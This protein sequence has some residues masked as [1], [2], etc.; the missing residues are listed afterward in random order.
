MDC[1]GRYFF[2]HLSAPSVICKFQCC[3]ILYE[4]S[5]EGLVGLLI[6]FYNEL[7][8]LVIIFLI[9]TRARGA[10]PIY[11]HIIRPFIKPYTETLDCLLDFMF[12]I[13][14]IA[15]AM[16]GVPV[17]TACAFWKKKFRHEDIAP[18]K[19]P[20]DHGQSF[21]EIG[22]KLNGNTY[23]SHEPSVIRSQIPEPIVVHRTDSGGSSASSRSKLGETSCLV[24]GQS[25]CSDTAREHEIWYP[26]PSAYEEDDGEYRNITQKLQGTSSTFTNSDASSVQQVDEW[27]QYP[28]FPA[29]YPPTPL[30]TLMRLSS[31][32]GNSDDTTRAALP[33]ID[34]MSR[35]DFRQSLLPPSKT[36]DPG[37]DGA[38]SDEELNAGVHETKDD[39]DRATLIDPDASMGDSSTLDEEEEDEFNVTLQTPIPAHVLTK[40][41]LHAP[42][43]TSRTTSLATTTSVGS[44]STGLSTAENGSSLRTRTSLDSL[45][46]AFISSGEDSPVIGKKRPLPISRNASSR[47]ARSVNEPGLEPAVAE[48]P[49]GDGRHPKRHAP[50]SQSLDHQRSLDDGNKA[51]DVKKR[52]LAPLNKTAVRV[53]KSARPRLARAVSPPARF[54]RKSISEQAKPPLQ[55]RAHGAAALRTSKSVTGDTLTPGANIGRFA[56]RRVLA[57]RGQERKFDENS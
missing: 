9:L 21:S 42:R 56:P 28:Q 6:P 39:D 8:S 50:I 47:N 57:S 1:L 36:T 32:S 38:L 25:T 35:Q 41:F 7:K 31:K 19:Q 13:C 34:D 54:Q 20:T 52:R 5:L 26:P 43:M 22:D 51:S 53:S 45:S 23:L 30:V 11:L 17:R 55:A 33:K 48:E 46:S 27:R 29:A 40:T 44:R 18:D 12:L 49:T 4:R 16:V 3:Y 14:D 2:F 24:A 37:L 15:L 10:E